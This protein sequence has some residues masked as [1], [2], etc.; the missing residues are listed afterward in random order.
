MHNSLA[1]DTA[2]QSALRFNY[3]QQI[4]NSFEIASSTFNTNFQNTL[5]E[6]YTNE[7]TFDTDLNDAIIHATLNGSYNIIK[8][9]YHG[10]KKDLSKTM[11]NDYKKAVIN[12]LPSIMRLKMPYLSLDH[13]QYGILYGGS[14]G[15]LY[16]FFSSIWHDV[17]KNKPLLEEKISTL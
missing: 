3:L 7:K 2:N 14:M 12:E 13:L 1:V 15:A 6:I 11:L 5:N 16:G 8:I 17:I 10:I 9:I 4:R